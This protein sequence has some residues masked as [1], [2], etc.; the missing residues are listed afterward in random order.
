[1]KLL[2][3]LILLLLTVNI[4]AQSSI[5]PDVA[6]AVP[7]PLIS[8]YKNSCI[9]GYNEIK[10]DAVTLPISEITSKG[11]KKEVTAEGKVIDIIYGI[12]NSQKTTVLEVQRNYELALKNSGLEIVYSAFGKNKFSRYSTISR[13]YETF[14]S[15]KYLTTFETQKLKN[16]RFI[17][18]KN[19]KD[20]NND[21]AYFVAQGKKNGRNYTM[22]LFIKYNRTS[23]ADLTNNIFIQVKIIESEAMDTGQVS[24][25]SIEEKIKNEGKEVFHNILFDFG[26]DNLTLESYDI[27]ETLAA[28]LN[29]DKNKKYYIVGHTDNVG[30][31]SSNQILSEKRAKAV[32]LALTSKYNVNPSQLTAHGIGQLSPLAINTYEEGRALNRRVEIV[33]R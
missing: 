18:S 14:G 27:I 7:H 20:Q 25:A 28:Y 4:Y 11:A 12:E 13:H 2:K 1:M 3:T 15:T 10:F 6:G 21:M 8:K 5:C 26:S 17:F 29:S 9:I 24:I 22:A 19:N 31:L 23:W 30:S 16:F 32:V 33:L